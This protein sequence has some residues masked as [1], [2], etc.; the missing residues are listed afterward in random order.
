MKEWLRDNIVSTLTLA[1]M[2]AAAYFASQYEGRLWTT[3]ESRVLGEDHVTNS[4]SEKD[5]YDEL[6]TLDSLNDFAKKDAI[7][8]L[9]RDSIRDD[10]VERNSVSIYRIEKDQDTIKKLLKQYIQM[11]D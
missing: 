8:N 6:K 10:K 1:A 3:T 9:T 4:K 5:L 7:E 11:H 2:L